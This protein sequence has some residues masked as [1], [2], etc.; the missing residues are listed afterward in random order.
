[1][2][3]HFLTG[4]DV[5]PIRTTGAGMFGDVATRFRRADVSFF[6][7]ELP[8]S[9]RGEPVPGKAICHR[10]PPAS[11]DGLVE[12]GVT[13]VNLANN[14]IL[15]FGA[16]A[17]FDTLAL[18][19]RHGI[20]RFGA[21]RDVAAARVAHVVEKD[22][23][24]VGF[25]GYTTTLPAGFAATPERPGVN[26][27]QAGTDAG[28][29]ARAHPGAVSAPAIVKRADPV[30]LQALRDA[31][32]RLRDE[33]EIVIVYVH[34]GASMSPRVHDYQQEIGRAAIDAG[35]HGVFGGH[36][37]VISGIESYR[38]CP[39]VHGSGNLLFDTW[40]SFFTDETRKTFLFGATLTRDGLRNCHAL[41]V[42]AGVRVP[43]RLLSRTDPSW[44]A[45]FTDLQA[46]SLALG[47]EVVARGDALEVR[48]G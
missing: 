21:G 23:I 24:R 12:A 7:L 37:H 38:G 43:P 29:P 32:R 44:N 39:I 8:L 33:A 46:R 10:G 9:E 20:G 40:P 18:L 48:C 35:A 1:M 41:P 22:G 11:V 14:H 19:D 15:D 3:I 42:S 45:I 47:T 26:P 25:L 17:M 28:P 16:D 2:A 36:Q 31:V 13:C 6:N 4:G 30:H 27:I 5:A 34:W